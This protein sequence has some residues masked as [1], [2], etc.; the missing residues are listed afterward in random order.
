M[1]GKL[2]QELILYL[3]TD[4]IGLS[5]LSNITVA[6]LLQEK[7][8]CGNAAHTIMNYKTYKYEKRK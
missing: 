6:L 3:L 5:H 7:V 1:L 4:W 8:C 2:D